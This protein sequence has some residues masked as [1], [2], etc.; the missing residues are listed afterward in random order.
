M[1]ETLREGSVVAIDRSLVE[2]DRDGQQARMRRATA[3]LPALAAIALAA[4]SASAAPRFGD[5]I[6]VTRAAPRAVVAFDAEGRATALAS[7]TASDPGPP[8]VFLTHVSV[9]TRPRGGVFGP[10]ERV[11]GPV[12]EVD[13]LDLAVNGAGEAVAVWSRGSSDDPRSWVVEAA[14]R[15]AG[16]S[17]GVPERL[18]TPGQAGIQVDADIAASGEAVV[19]WTETSPRLR[20]VRRTPLAVHAA[21]RPGGGRWSVRRLSGSQDAS[22]PH[23]AL[24]PTGDGLVVWEGLVSGSRNVAAYAALRPSSG[25][26]GSPRR[27]SPRG[28]RAGV[29]VAAAGA[30]GRAVVAWLR[31][32]RLARGPRR[33]AYRV[34]AVTGSVRGRFAA[35][36]FLSAPGAD[37]QSVAVGPGGAVAAWHYVSPTARARGPR[38]QAAL[39]G[40]RG[41]F[42][43]PATLSRPA[44][45]LLYSDVG[46]DRSG[47]AV[48]VW[49]RWV[50]RSAAVVEAS[51]GAE[52]RFGSARAISSR[53]R[54]ADPGLA[55]DPRGGG[56]A[57]WETSRPSANRVLGRLLTA[58]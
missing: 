28:A 22:R 8:P 49:S 12:P 23:V 58:E 9:A 19:A 54:F 40:A 26:F 6:E 47:A 18:S 36:R 34:E 35:P 1:C 56:L 7:V 52:G 3:A 31:R 45:S 15:P 10:L 38:V 4:P 21:A 51:I 57:Y 27:L 55:L 50:T 5:P 37:D 39:A 42:G 44:A 48:V 17:F 32:V 20:G 24:A 29:P 16:G 53:G 30:E 11:S 43:A 25:T 14:Y 13:G 46:V 33:F 41:G 2:D